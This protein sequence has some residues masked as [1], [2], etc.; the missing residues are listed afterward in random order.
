MTGP[1]TAHEI[2]EAEIYW[3]RYVQR[4]AF[5]EDLEA[6][7]NSQA[8]VQKSRLLRLHPFLNSTV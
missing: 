4:E 8:C 3:I 5:P 6:L 1:L 7:L 2:Q